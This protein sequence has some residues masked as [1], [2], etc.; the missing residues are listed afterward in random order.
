MPALLSDCRTRVTSRG[1]EE[2]FLMTGHVGSGKRVAVVGATGAVGTEMVKVLHTRGS[3]V[4][5]LDLYAS[6]R[7][8]ER[9]IA[10]PYGDRTVRPF[11]LEAARQADI[12]LLAVSGDFAKQYGP[13]LTEQGGIVIDNSSA[14]RYDPEIP[15][16]VPEI[17]AAAIAG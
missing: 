14:F 12:I 1:D 11:T 2:I 4:A 10:T 13:A 16:V 17:N 3:P 5:E 8:A 15:L 6:E 7:S 9:V